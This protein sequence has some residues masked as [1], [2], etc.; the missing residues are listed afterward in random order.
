MAERNI[1]VVDIN[2]IVIDK[3]KKD[4]KNGKPYF[5]FD[6]EQGGQTKKWRLFTAKDPQAESMGDSIKKGDNVIGTGEITEG[7]YQGQPTK[8]RNL[9]HISKNEEEV[10]TNSEVE[11]TSPKN[12]Q[13]FKDQQKVK[14]FKSSDADKF[15]LGMAK[16]IS[17]E[18]IKAMDSA[19]GKTKEELLKEYKENVI[20]IFDI[21]KKI[22]EE[23]LGY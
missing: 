13:D 16:N 15:E 8:Y 17:I 6:I 20:I 4:D 22:R 23:L 19:K 12:Y 14:D 2:G 1:E 5:E 21:N 3:P 7:T 9:K 11:N 18:L 10:K